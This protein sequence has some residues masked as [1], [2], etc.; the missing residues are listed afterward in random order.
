MNA[1]DHALELIEFGLYVLP[2]HVVTVNGKQVK[3]PLLPSWQNDATC[4]PMV[5]RH[6]FTRQYQHASVGI[7]HR[8]SGTMAVDLDRHREGEDGIAVMAK[9]LEIGFPWPRTAN[10][11]T[12]NGH[13]Y[14]FS[15]PDSG[16][17]DS[18][19]GNVTKSSDIGFDDG[20]QLIWGFSAAPSGPTTPGRLWVKTPWEWDIATIPTWIHA[21]LDAKRAE[22]SIQKS[23]FAPTR[24][25]V[26]GGEDR[27]RAYCVA[28]INNTADRIGAAP[29]GRRQTTLRDEAFLCGR[30]IGTKAMVGMLADAEQT[31]LRSAPWVDT[32]RERS[33][34][35]RALDEGYREGERG[36]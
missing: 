15:R 20:V 1:L 19:A 29:E 30:A 22:R 13:Q 7:A 10:F 25:P 3:K 26:A 2:W 32:R 33:T 24:L 36:R 12:P 34:L 31:L 21:E 5:A 18:L 23:V 16:E 14:I 11:Q 35:V 9:V 8:L 17:Y 27:D 6:W 4:D 28:V